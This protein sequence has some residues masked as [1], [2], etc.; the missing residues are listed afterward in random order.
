MKRPS[1]VSALAIAA[2]ML[3]ALAFTDV[4]PV[5]DDAIACDQNVEQC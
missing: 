1:G 3:A 2:L 5:V 4:L